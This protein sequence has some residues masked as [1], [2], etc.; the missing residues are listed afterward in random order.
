MSI[1]AI[2]RNAV[3]GAV[4][5]ARLPLDVAVSLLPRDGDSAR[6]AA[7]IAID[8]WDAT[9]RQIAGFAL[10]DEEMRADAIR[11]R[12]AADERAR[13]LRLQESAEQRRAA[14]DERLADRVEH[15]EEQREAAEARAERQRRQATE[16]RAERTA[17]A[18]RTEAR[19]KA[20]N[21]KSHGQAEEAI[22]EE[23]D[24]AR[25][26]QLEAE[27]EVIE[28]RE[29]ALTAQSEA[30]RLQDAATARKAARKTG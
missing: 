22:E 17:S 25:V 8:R 13:A 24:Q 5:L 16:Q 27:A 14:A 15:A 20:A 11:R 10:H 4:K 26:E 29:R 19:R 21:R 3:G 2:P 7:R 18:A 1:R 9:V 28:E 6:P 12:A 23:A 30:Q